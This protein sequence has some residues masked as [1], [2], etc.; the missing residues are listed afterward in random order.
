MFI[1]SNHEKIYVLFII[2]ISENNSK[3]PVVSQAA[4][5]DCG[6]SHCCRKVAK[7][8]TEARITDPDAPTL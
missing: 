7:A 6:S 2:L 3:F 1:V 8:E 4:T 5:G